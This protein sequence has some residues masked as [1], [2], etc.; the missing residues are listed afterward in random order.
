MSMKVQFEKCIYL[1]DFLKVCAQAISD[2]LLIS[3]ILDQHLDLFQQIIGVILDHQLNE[4]AKRHG[5]PDV[6]VPQ[7]AL[8]QKGPCVVVGQKD[9]ELWVVRPVVEGVLILTIVL[10][11]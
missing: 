5:R 6:L 10:E 1:L 4:L 9:T 11:K 3:Q 8:Q 7:Q 2:E